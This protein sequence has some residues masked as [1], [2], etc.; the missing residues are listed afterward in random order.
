MDDVGMLLPNLKASSWRN[1]SRVSDPTG[2]RLRVRGW[3]YP[4]PVGEIS[5]FSKRV[6]G[7]LGVVHCEVI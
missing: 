7:N 1:K 6:E 3:T 2:L 5:I 4:F